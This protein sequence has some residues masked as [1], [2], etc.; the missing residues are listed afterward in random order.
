MEFRILGPLEVT[1]HGSRLEIGRGKE[2]SVLAIL[3]LHA[4]EVVSSDRL[5]DELW[6][7][8]PPATAAK[9]VQVYV[10]RLRKALAG[11]GAPGSRDAVLLTRG[12]GYALRVEP[13]QLDAASFQQGLAQAER[14]LAAGAP[15]EASE[16]LRGAL[17]LW[18][19]AALDDFAYE[20]FAELDI[21]RLEELRLVAIEQRIDAD[22]ELGRHAA[23]A[24]ELETLVARHPLRERF[25]EQL[26]LA[27]YRSGRQ[28]EALQAYRRARHVLIGGAGLDPGEPLRALE[29]AILAH[30][31]ALAPA[32]SNGGARTRADDDAST[33][34][35]P[36][37]ARLP[38][39]LTRYPLALLACGAVVLGAA[40]VAAMSRL[41]GGS[42]PVRPLSAGLLAPDTVGRIDPRT[43]A[44]LARVAV[45]GGPAR[46][47][48]AGDEPWVAADRSRTLS[49]IA[50]R[51][52]AMSAIVGRLSFPTDLALGNGAAWVLD[53]VSGR[54]LKISRAYSS[55]EGSVTI[56][57][58][59]A[60]SD[61]VEDRLVVENPWSV[62]IGLG[63]V[64]VTDGSRDL[65]RVDPDTSKVVGAID[66]GHSLNGVAVGEG[67]VWTISGRAAT[68]FRI[69]PR[70]SRVT[71]R[72]PIGHPGPQAPYPIAIEVGLG[73]VWVLNANVAT[74]TRIDAH[75]RIVTARKTIGVER[76]PQRLAVGD[77]A[78]WVA[79]RDGTLSRIDAETNATTNFAI[80]HGLLDVGV[81]PGAVWVT[82]TSGVGALPS[83][84]APA[85]MSSGLRALPRSRCSPVYYQPGKR[86]RFLI[87]SDLPLQGPRGEVTNEMTKAIHFVLSANHFT[88]GRYAVGYQA[89]DDSTIQESSLAA[90]RCPSNA[91]AYA[92]DGSV[93]G[94][95]GP[96][97]SD[98][99]T[100]EIPIANRPRHG[101][102]PLISA[103][104]TAVGLTRPG[105]GVP[106]GDP[107][108]YYPT[109]T[110][111]Y[112][113]VIPADDFQGAAD[114]MLAQRLGLKR[115]FTLKER[116]VPRERDPYVIGITSAFRWAAQKLGIAIAGSDDWTLDKSSYADLAR[117]V[118]RSRADGVF[119]GGN[120]QHGGGRLIK[121]LRGRLG[122]RVQFMSPDGFAVPELADLTGPAGDGITVSTPGVL[123]DA[124]T[125][126]GARFVSR[127]SAVLGQPPEQY[128]IYAAQATQLLLHAI[129]RSNGTRASVNHELFASTVHNG[130]LG[131]FAI[132]P[133][134]DT[135]TNK[136]TIY[137]L[138]A[139]KLKRLTVITVP[140][141][142]IKTF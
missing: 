102:L 31:P 44:I 125:V 51:K 141:S 57:R 96:F 75:E 3:L 68:V 137:R 133:T 27:L 60:Q 18:R 80:G 61:P 39:F 69:D 11:G 103:T 38:A 16:T 73:S 19:G 100:A 112:V 87:A 127:F 129:A 22:L 119:L 33:A 25:W 115:V 21:A 12:G 2:R 63:G 98:C 8:A 104:T 64:W 1:E 105:A 34:S 106:P 126:A 76:G 67:A 36:R 20:P 56:D 14:L 15:A 32:P 6:G 48:L 131:D 120:V 24:P 118:K 117:K 7:E 50:T 140:S 85:P 62:A 130:I 99:A 122:A 65:V 13:G 110:R 139:G 55:I 124:L 82:A 29:R 49:A 91:H 84:P 54:L 79:N 59:R 23:V 109:G 135:T 46:L 28:T 41:S 97:N 108:R 47:A 123:P 88:A 40:V 43:G 136:V 142:L 30:D 93:I 113:R 138:T 132:T 17:A 134:G 58:R 101:P 45:P 66:V 95:I 92:N 70:T 116:L 78:A 72:I 52:G 10:S 81:G 9:S 83:A 121:E 77:G 90:S 53:G 71:A 35:R 111:N 107:D 86:P 4:N 114:A 42:P 89:C 94:V 5:I 128:S 74:V 26:M 37:R